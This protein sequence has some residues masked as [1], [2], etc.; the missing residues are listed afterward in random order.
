[1]AEINS[2]LGRKNF[3]STGN[4][5]IFDIPDESDRVSGAS[6]AAPPQP[7][8]NPNEWPQG[9][10]VQLT[11]EQFNAL[12]AQHQSVKEDSKKINSFSRDRIN[13]LT[14]I[15][16]TTTEAK[17]DD[18]VFVLQSLK[19]REM[20]EIMQLVTQKPSSETFFELRTQTL[21]RS[22]VSVD[23]HHINDILGDSS[24]ETKLYFVN[25]CEEYIVNYLYS[26]YLK[27]AQKLSDQYSA[28][29]EEKTKEVV[30]DIKK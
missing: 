7:S 2:P 11:P 18:H 19:A 3:T 10:P 13:I 14:N 22:L 24:L 23:G 4:Q 6:P 15:G 25:E 5:K 26:T 28:D 9:V 17:I 16:R 30:E 8:L 29:T 12:R 20:K 21:V 27:M 1:M